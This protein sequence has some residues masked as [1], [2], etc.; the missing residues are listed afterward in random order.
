MFQRLGFW[1]KIFLHSISFWQDGF[2]YAI[3]YCPTWAR[4]I[5]GDMYNILVR[6]FPEYRVVHR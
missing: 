5:C 3:F 6:H 1:F 4:D 2:I